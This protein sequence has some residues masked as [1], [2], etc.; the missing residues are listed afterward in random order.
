MRA[1]NRKGAPL[2]HLSGGPVMNSML[3]SASSTQGMMS[4]PRMPGHTGGERGGA[5]VCGR[6]GDAK[7]MCG[8]QEAGAREAEPARR[9][10]PGRRFSPAAR[11]PHAR[12]P[13]RSPPTPLARP[14]PLLLTAPVRP[15]TSR[16][17]PSSSSSSSSSARGSKRPCGSL[18][19]CATPLL[20]THT[21][22]VPS[23]STRSMYSNRPRPSVLCRSRE[24]GWERDRSVKRQHVLWWRRRGSGR[25]PR[26]PGGS[27]PRL[28]PPASPAPH[29][30]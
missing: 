1:N 26:Q 21:G 11:R 13:S 29:L 27:R 16:R 19:P 20:M 17:R 9:P 22:S 18:S 15:T 12:I 6:E 2:G 10:L 8:R 28:G 5:R 30:Q 4:A 3:S 24:T 7:G 14:P 25:A 23:S